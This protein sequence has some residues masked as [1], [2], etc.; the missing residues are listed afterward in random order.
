[1]RRKGHTKKHRMTR[2]KQRGGYYGFSGGLATGAP[3]WKTGSEMGD[4]AVN[5]AGNATYGA[6]RRRKHSKK[7]RRHRKMR[8]GNKFGGVAA[9]FGGKGTAGMADYSAVSTR[10]APGT[11]TGGAFNDNGAGPNSGH[12]SFVKAH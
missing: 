6:G 8:G 10:G 4:F 9:S 5:R 3:D 12:A 7:T 2:S 11:P 1:M